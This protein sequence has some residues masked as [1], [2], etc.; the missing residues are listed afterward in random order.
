MAEE[1]KDVE[2]EAVGD[3]DDEDDD[4]DNIL[5]SKKPV[6]TGDSVKKC[7]RY[8][9]SITYDVY[10]QTPR[11]WL[12]GIDENKQ[13]MERE[14]FEDVMAEHAKKTVTLETHPH[15]DGALQ[16]TIHPCEHASMMKKFLCGMQE[17]GATPD[18]GIYL[19]IFL[20][21]FSSVIPTIKYDFTS[22]V[23]VGYAD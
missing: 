8:N 17:N 10:Y 16:A 12:T 3:I 2:E 18:V 9:I 19:F 6:E 5:A 1:R 22:D 14:I 20:K 23:D 15:A 11:L 7:R 21:F 4:D 13:V